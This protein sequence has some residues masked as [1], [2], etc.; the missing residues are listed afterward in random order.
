MHPDKVQSSL[1]KAIA[2]HQR[3]KLSEAAKLYRTILKA[4]PNNPDGLHYLGLLNFNQGNSEKAVVMILAALAIKPDYMDAYLNLGN[5]YLS[6]ANLSNAQKCYERALELNPNHLGAG[7]N[8]G[9]LHRYTGE[10]EK[11]EA[12][13]EKVVELA[14]TFSGSYINLAKTQMSLK[15]SHQALESY[16][17]AIT[18]DPQETAFYSLAIKASLAS[19][20]LDKAQKFINQLREI[21]PENPRLQHIHAALSGNDVPLRASDAYV[22]A[23]FDAYAESFDS[24]LARLEYCAPELLNEQLNN[25]YQEKGN[26]LNVL[27]AGCGTG[28]AHNYLKPYAKKLVGMDISS[29]M[30]EKARNKK[31]YDKLL[32]QSLEVGI[33]NYS[34]YFDLIVCLDTVIY[35]G[36]LKQLFSAIGKALSKKG[37]FIF[38]TERH[39]GNQN[40]KLCH[41]GRYEHSKDY[42]EHAL[43]ES[44]LEMKS[45]E[46]RVIRK[47]FGEN[48][49]GWLVTARKHD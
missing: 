36:D 32:C 19:K 26:S 43:S 22:V 47:E 24:S 40:Y 13:L 42:L 49:E 9:I 1:K 45:I 35:F 27:D 48:V 25:I 8:L 28:L 5:I 7:S 11:S 12:L 15:K 38:T 4:E 6:V 33:S 14:P 18:L 21:N 34:D 39:K 10:L 17:K 23:E 44:S 20:Q 2:L 3:Y 31:S 37:H 30:L 46:N 29:K 41:H 16:Q